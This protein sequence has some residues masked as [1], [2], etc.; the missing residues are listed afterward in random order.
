ME[1]VNYQYCTYGLIPRASWKIIHKNYFFI[2]QMHESDVLVTQ[3]A[4]PFITKFPR[5]S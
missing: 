4:V 2:T 3:N 1:L 5:P